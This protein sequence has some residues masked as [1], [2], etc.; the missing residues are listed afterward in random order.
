VTP[1]SG[2]WRRVEA[3]VGLHDERVSTVIGSDGSGLEL[4]P[5]QFFHFF[6]DDFRTL[7]S[8]SYRFLVEFA[9]FALISPHI[10]SRA[11]G[12]SRLDSNVVD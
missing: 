9:R 4:M 1:G 5:R 12:Q 3:V 11:T 10:K 6:L 2:G 8:T 7:G